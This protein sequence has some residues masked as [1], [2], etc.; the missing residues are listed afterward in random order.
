MSEYTHTQTKIELGDRFWGS[1]GAQCCVEL[2]NFSGAIQWC[3][4]GLKFYP[5]D[6]KLM[7]LRASADKHKVTQ[8]I[9]LFELGFMRVATNE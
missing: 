6:N 4:E 2:R 1:A 9:M 5:T 8:E 3:D 7:E